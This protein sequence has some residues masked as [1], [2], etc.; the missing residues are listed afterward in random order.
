MNEATVLQGAHG[1]ARVHPIGATVVSWVPHG[2]DDVLWV[3]SRAH[4]E[5][6]RAIRGGIPLCWPWFADTGTPA[7]GLVRTRRWTLLSQKTVDGAA[8]AEWG[9]DHDDGD[10]AFSLRYRVTVD[11][12]LT[13]QLVHDDRSGRSRSISGCLHTYL[14]LDAARARVHGLDAVG[15]DKLTGADR[16]VEGPTSLSGPVDLVV[17]HS[18]PVTVEDGPRRLVIEGRG[19]RDVVLWNPGHAEVSQLTPGEEADFGCVE[20][21]IVSSAVDVPG[22]ASVTLGARLRLEG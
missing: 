13:L 3:A 8:S 11:R 18:G 9:L 12:D 5:E 1:R 10:W 20:T 7:H 17:P 22:G 16:R 21:A 6:G 4:F 14:R 2:H 15:F 19:H